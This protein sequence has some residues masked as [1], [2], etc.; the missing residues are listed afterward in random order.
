MKDFSHFG[1]RRRKLPEYNYDALWYNLKTLRLGEGVTQELPAND[2]EFYDIALNTKCNAECSF[3]YVSATSKGENYEGI[4]ETF[5]KWINSL[6]EDIY[7]E[8]KGYTLTHKPFQIA[9]G[10]TGEVTIHP[11]LPRFLNIVYHHHIVPN[12]TTNGIVLSQD[13]EYT[14]EL[15]EATR[16]Y[17][18]GVAI[19]VSN[20]LI[21]NKAERAIEKLILEGNTNINLHHIISDNKSVDEFLHLY[22]KYNGDILYHV[23][24]PLMPSGRSTKSVSVESF[25]YL[26]DCIIKYDITNIAYGAHFYDFLLKGTNHVWLYP[27]E[28]LSKNVI[29]KKDEVI[30]TPSSFNLTPIKTLKFNEEI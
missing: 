7:L 20:Q 21:R 12:Y 6:P 15:L 23:L 4:C 18:G 16:R 11:D 25:N 17:V 2:S 29:L 27:P 19:S 8:D 10:S 5:D 26:Q 22:Q 1:I 30:F 3:C 13:S 24:L 14:D 9:C 28:S